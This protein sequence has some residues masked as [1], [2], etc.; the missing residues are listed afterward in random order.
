M[1]RAAASKGSSDGARRKR[2]AAILARST[3]WGWH[4]RRKEEVSQ[5][6]SIGK[7]ATAK[8]RR[9]CD[10][11]SSKP[12]GA[13][14]ACPPTPSQRHVTQ[15]RHEHEAKPIST[16]LTTTENKISCTKEYFV[17]SLRRQSSGRFCR[18]VIRLDWGYR[19]LRLV[20]PHFSLVTGGFNRNDVAKWSFLFN[21]RTN[22]GKN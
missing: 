5:R 3:N 7:T 4:C 15:L 9:R 2:A 12:Q 22:A 6:L 13:L 11:P 18:C 21:L 1:R 17:P 8:E 16:N 10:L 19:V 20:V 14:Q